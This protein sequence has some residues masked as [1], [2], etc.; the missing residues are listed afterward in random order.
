MEDGVGV[1][2]DMVHLPL[3]PDQIRYH[4]RVKPTD[5][6]QHVM[7]IVVVHF[8]KIFHENTIFHKVVIVLV[9]VQP[10][11]APQRICDTLR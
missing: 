9:H 6:A 1:A 8:S 7:K 10:L 2:L 5:H 3:L 4:F 11:R